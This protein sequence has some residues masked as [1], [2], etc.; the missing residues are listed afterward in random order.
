MARR[1]TSRKLTRRDA[2]ALLGA[3]TVA[4]AVR[5]VPTGAREV[6]QGGPSCKQEAPVG[7]FR[8]GSLLALTSYSCCEETRNA[9]LVG[10]EDPGPTVKPNPIGKAHLK[11]LQTRLNSDKLEEYCLMIW[12]LSDSQV[13]KFFEALPVQLGFEKR[14]APK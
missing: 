13:R 12:G 3:G 9:I 14:D 1:T 8:N 11:A 4:G 7:T 5:T 6:V 2:V 10:V